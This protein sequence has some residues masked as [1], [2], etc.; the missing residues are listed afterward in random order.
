MMR[1]C[2]VPG[3]CTGKYLS[4]RKFTV[5]FKFELERQYKVDINL[6]S[7]FFIQLLGLNGHLGAIV[8]SIG[9]VA[10]TP[11]LNIGGQGSVDQINHGKYKSRH[12]LPSI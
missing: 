7:L 6:D 1:T 9:A 10:I 12:N 8:I 5:T 11:T 3:A 2:S 4:C